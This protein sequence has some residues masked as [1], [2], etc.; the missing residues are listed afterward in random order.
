MEYF[1]TIIL[2]VLLVLIVRESRAGSQ[3]V[4]SDP[5]VQLK[6]SERFR[7]LRMQMLEPLVA[8]VVVGSLLVTDLEREPVHGLAA[9]VGAAAGYAFGAYRARSTY[10]AAVPAHRGVILRYSVESF[11]A[12]GLLIVI[13]IVA[14]QNLL[15]DGDIFRIV[16]A[17]LLGFLLMES[18]A[19]VFA[20]V[21]RYRR[22]ESAALPAA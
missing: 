1:S 4:K 11:V 10:V 5:N 17:A 22:D 21:R 16:L 9:L 19:R 12:L 8:L 3:A 15:P 18:F 14:E 7:T 2:V 20:L 13:K 6:P